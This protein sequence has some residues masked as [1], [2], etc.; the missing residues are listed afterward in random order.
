MSTDL[1]EKSPRDL[2]EVIE[3]C[4]D[5]ENNHYEDDSECVVCHSCKEWTCEVRCRE[6]GDL[7]F[8]SA[9]CA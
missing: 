4:C 8:T 2:D 6:C 5:D 7:L 3:S 9:C 1:L